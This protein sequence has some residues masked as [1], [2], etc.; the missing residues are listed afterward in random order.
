MATFWFARP[1]SVHPWTGLPRNTGSDPVS[2][3]S[4]PPSRERA[5][6]MGTASRLAPLSSSAVDEGTHDPSSTGPGVSEALSVKLPLPEPSVPTTT[7]KSP[8]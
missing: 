5:P 8:P 4:T 6:S 7:W 3:P 2:A 1:S